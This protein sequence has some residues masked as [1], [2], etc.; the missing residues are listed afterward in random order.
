MLKSIQ[1]ISFLNPNREDSEVYC[2]KFS[3]DEEFFACGLGNSKVKVY[4]IRSNTQVNSLENPLQNSVPATSVAFRPNHSS[5]KTKSVLAV[6]CIFHFNWR[7]IL[8]IDADGK[9]RHWHYTSGKLL[10]TIEE[11]DN[12]I[13]YLGYRNDGLYFLTAGSDATVR[14]Y[15]TVTSKSTHALKYGTEL[16]SSGHS[17]RIFSAKFHPKDS[18]AVLSAGW[19]NTVQIWDLRASKSVASIYG[20][21]VCGDALDINDDGSH[22]LTGSHRSENP[23]QIWDWRTRKLIDSICWSGAEGEMRT[24]SLLY[25]A[26]YSRGTES[27]AGPCHNR[28]IIAGGCNSN[29]MRIFTADS[30][31][32]F[33][34]IS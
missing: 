27:L 16:K 2:I 25:S 24:S 22:I 30:H 3:P 18:N 7:L 13:N 9:I 21:Y 31:R 19:D 23:L 4:S 33:F 32:V 14:I 28:F 15:D 10:S 8:Y 11:P 6:A 34:L 29:E 1:F 17:N 12:D 5:F 20:P 26:S